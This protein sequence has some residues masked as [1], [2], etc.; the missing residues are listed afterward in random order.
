MTS[1][2]DMELEARSCGG[3]RGFPVGQHMVQIS[4][5]RDAY[6]QN[7]EL[8]YYIGG[9]RVDRVKVVALLA[10]TPPETVPTYAE[11]LAQGGL[12]LGTVTGG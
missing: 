9:W 6:T 2:E 12:K 8:L 10:G 5:Y 7:G 1:L 3:M 4:Y 11:L